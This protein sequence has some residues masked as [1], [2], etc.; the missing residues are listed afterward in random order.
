MQELQGAIPAIRKGDAEQS[1]G[2]SSPS[3]CAKR[4][5]ALIIDRRA[6]MATEM[7]RALA[8]NNFAVS[9]VGDAA[10]PAFYSR[11][12]SRNIVVP[13]GELKEI[14]PKLIEQVLAAQQYDA[15]FICNEEI[16]EA[17]L[18]HVE[19]LESPGFVLSSKDTL[20]KA[21]SKRA[22]LEL[23]GS[24]GIA[25][26][27]TIA[28]TQLPELI[29]AG[30]ELGFPLVVK[31]DRGEAG[32]HVR[33]VE[34]PSRLVASYREIASLENSGEF[35]PVLQEF[36]RGWAYSVGGLYYRGKPLRVCA[37]RKVI[38]VPP[39]GGLTVRGETE[40]Q[41]GLLEAAFR[42][43]D[44]LNYTGLGHIEF[45]RDIEQRF[46]F[47]EINPRSWGTI[48]VGAV[49]GVDFFTPY[50]QLAAGVIPAPDLRF[51][52]GVKFHRLNRE[53]KLLRKNPRRL[54]GLIF[55][56]CNPAIR[57]DFSWSDPLPH[58]GTLGHRA[59]Q[60]LIPASKPA[61]V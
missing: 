33:L 10:S 54:F 36:V 19:L 55:D 14:Y 8:R 59:L 28:P 45:I 43:F 27:R 26:P 61:G 25:T 47:L 51:K 6:V 11:Y 30:E 40:N 50:A 52:E 37:H 7:C 4:A 13:R 17:L 18:A 22:M 35:G 12:C 9:V 60:K 38:G 15:I 42:V 2:T 49:A 44:A 53:G 16:L 23:A 39:L 56:C 29:A 48:G 46:Q 34:D 41:P 1:D 21:L 24:I 58:F 5:Q 20:R 57:S 3:S 32:G 31:G